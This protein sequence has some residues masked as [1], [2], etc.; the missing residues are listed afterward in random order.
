MLMKMRWRIVAVG[1][2]LGAAALGIGMAQVQV[3]PLPLGEEI[4]IVFKRD[5][6]GA[7]LVMPHKGARQSPESTNLTGFLVSMD[8]LWACVRV[9][10]L[11][12]NSTK[13]IYDDV[14]VA[15]DSI[16]LMVRAD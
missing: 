5:D 12:R 13:V 7:S 6:V 16:L 4:T 9:E 1:A 15:R 3:E 2:L 10:R 8:Q 11:V 14:W